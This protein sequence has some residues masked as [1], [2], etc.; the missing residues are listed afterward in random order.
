MREYSMHTTEIIPSIL[1]HTEEEFTSAIKAVSQSVSMVQID[2]A[3]GVFVPNTTW[4]EPD[5]IADILD[6]DCELHLMTSFPLEEVRN[7]EFVDQVKRVFVHYESTND[8][9][10]TVNAIHSYGWQVGI[11]LNPDTDV[12]VIDDYK[13]EIDAV[14]L[15]GVI[16]GFQGQEFIKETLD[17]IKKLRQT[18]P[19][20]YISIDGAVNESTIE[21][22]VK[23]GASAVCPGS[24]IFGNDRKPEEN[25]QRMKRI[26]QTAAK[27]IS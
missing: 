2:I 6:I 18:Y 4:A 20:L 24:A 8:I 11:A 13:E 14:L 12:H 3:D 19:S 17:K 23:S 27:N 1:V 16:P 9:G 7:W 21:D 5:L 26:I 22:I 10:H 25:I 15:M